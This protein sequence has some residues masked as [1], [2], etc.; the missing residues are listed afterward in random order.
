MSIGE[1][2]KLAGILTVDDLPVEETTNLSKLI[3][4]EHPQ[5]QEMLA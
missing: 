2:G 1:T 3:K 5:Q 4:R